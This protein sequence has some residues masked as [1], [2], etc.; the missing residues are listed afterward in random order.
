MRAQR[1][2]ENVTWSVCPEALTYM[3][4]A[5]ELSLILEYLVFCSFLFVT[6]RIVGI[7]LFPI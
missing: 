7:W 3:S 6:K 2:L 1:G 4:T 5:F